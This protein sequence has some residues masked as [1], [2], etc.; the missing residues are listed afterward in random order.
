MAVESIESFDCKVEIPDWRLHLAQMTFYKWRDLG[1]VMDLAT[2]GA[3][4]KLLK[5][6]QPGYL[7][8]GPTLG[9]IKKAVQDIGYDTEKTPLCS[10]LLL[11][12]FMDK[13]LFL[14]GC[15]A[16]D[17][18]AILTINSQAPW[19]VVDGEILEPPLEFRIGAPSEKFPGPTGDLDCEG[20][21]V[22]ADTK[23]VL[24]SPFF[25]PD[26]YALEGCTMPLFV[27]YLPADLFRMVQPKSH[28]GRAVW[29]TWAYKFQFEKTGTFHK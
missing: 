22:L 21:P 4:S 9:D 7:S 27:C 23:Q 28:M 14:K 8:A 10:E 5:I 2:Q 17:I 13:Q 3:F 20:L 6:Q 26:R 29:L 15:L 18:M 11:T 25:L 19:S 12:E 24:A 1:N 16:W